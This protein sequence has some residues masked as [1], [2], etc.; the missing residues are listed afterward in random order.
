MHSI[1]AVSIMFMTVGLALSRPRFMRMRIDHAQ[2]AVLGA[3]L[4]VVLGV[5]P[6]QLV[7]D[8]LAFLVVPV[9]TIV[10][11]MTITV[12]AEQTGLFSYL[13]HRIAVAAGGSPRRLF[14]YIFATGSFTGTIFTN[15]A[16]V[17][18]FTPLVYQ[19]IESVRD[20]TWTD[21]NCFPFYF[22]VL[23]VA[24]VAGALIISNPINI[25]ASHFF[26]IGFLEYAAWMF[27]PALVSIVV[28]Y[29]GIW[30]FFRR[31]IPARFTPQV[32]QA[33]DPSRR[34][35]MITCAVALLATLAAFFSEPLTGLPTWLVA[36][37][38]AVFLLVMHGIVN[39]SSYAAVVRG[40]GWDVIVFLAGI[41]VI[42][43]A[44]AETVLAQ[45]VFP[46]LEGASQAGPATLT[47]ITALA[48]GS[49]SALI[50]NHPTAYIM[51]QIIQSMDLGLFQSK[52][53]LFAA[54]IGG[55]L[56]PKML[57][58]GSLAALMWFRILRRRGVEIPYRLYIKI[59]IPVTLAA[60]AL[61]VL[62]LNL[63][64]ALMGP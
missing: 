51:P 28:S 34:T 21:A 15:D 6:L 31:R 47:S 54:L 13:A 1:A 45:A 41:F 30:L 7:F 49:L 2:A 39:D 14:L 18:I 5:I 24:N 46:H 43:N 64:V 4:S 63:E 32:H 50:N 9:I 8:S 60:I 37:A 22:A 26:D 11:L 44:L 56:G 59:G 52:I 10:S 62:V 55:D 42:A 12:I 61:A 23:Y 38:A 3:M 19:L 35:A 58:I 33:V 40:I 57:P 48:A 27:L 53:L 29:G 16:A 17:L 25:I 20:D 36:L